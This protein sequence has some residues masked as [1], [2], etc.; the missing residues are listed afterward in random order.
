MNEQAYYIG[1]A[2][3][4][5][6]RRFPNP[7]AFAYTCLDYIKVGVG[8]SCH[9][10]IVLKSGARIS[11]LLDEAPH[12]PALSQQVGPIHV[13]LFDLAEVDRAQGIQFLSSLDKWLSGQ[14]NGLQ[15][16]IENRLFAASEHWLSKDL[17]NGLNYVMD[18]ENPPLPLQRVSQILRHSF[19]SYLSEPDISPQLGLALSHIGND[20]EVRV[21]VLDGFE[22]LASSKGMSSA[23]LESASSGVAQWSRCQDSSLVLAVPCAVG[24]F[25]SWGV[26]FAEFSVVNWRSGYE[27]YRDVLPRL[28]QEVRLRAV[29]A[30]ADELM[31]VTRLVLEHHDAP[32]DAFNAAWRELA[33]Y[34][35]FSV[36]EFVE[37]DGNAGSEEDCWAMTIRNRRGIVCPQSNP[38]FPARV[39]G[40]EGEA[41][42][43]FDNLAGFVGRSITELLDISSRDTSSLAQVLAHEFKNMSQEA[44][45]KTGSLVARLGRLEVPS[46]I[47]DDIETLHRQCFFINTSSLA[48]LYGLGTPPRNKYELINDLEE[49]RDVVHLAVSV[50]VGL[51]TRQRTTTFTGVEPL[52]DALRALA[53]RIGLKYPGESMTE[54]HEAIVLA[55]APF[56]EVVRNVRTIEAPEP[57]G[58]VTAEFRITPDISAQNI[59]IEMQ[60]EQIEASQPAIDAFHSESLLRFCE[61]TFSCFGMTVS[62]GELQTEEVEKGKFRVRAPT[63][64]RIA[65]LYRWRNPNG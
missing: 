3:V 46:R 27:I 63:T 12:V 25:Q 24:E 61:R 35:P 56:A 36:P 18:M 52:N 23:V 50:A 49:L 51:F 42:G 54:M 48:I 7:V 5:A 15:A 64:V 45:K 47:S 57:P 8:R 40:A 32:P 37:Q 39:G 28:V 62:F 59:V 20:D 65:R 9:I 13:S 17:A 33:R 4:A 14:S 2:L 30:Y 38:F 34:F 55:V 22:G 60:Q 16:A 11:E 53:T 31:R 1:D 26:F 6:L 29:V 44:V 21:C 19:K 58:H 41:W 43:D 10:E